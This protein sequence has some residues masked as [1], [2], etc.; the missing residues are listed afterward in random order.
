M[1][2]NILTAKDYHFCK[3]V[4]ILQDNVPGIFLKKLCIKP[5]CELDIRIIKP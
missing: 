2:Y 5:D 1:Y 4:P 3:Y